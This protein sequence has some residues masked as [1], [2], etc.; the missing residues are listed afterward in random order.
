[1]NKTCELIKNHCSIRSFNEVEVTKSQIDEIIACSM[2][3]ATAGNMMLY[4]IIK[5]DQQE[6]L[7][8]LSEKCDNQKF[9]KQASFA[10]LYLADAYK[11][12]EYF[13]MRGIKDAKPSIV[14]LML[15]T[16]DAM[17]AA[18]NAVIAAESMKIGTCYIGDIME[19][20][21]EIKTHF[22]LPNHVVPITLIVFGNYDSEVALRE[23]F[24]TKHIVFNETYPKITNDFLI[25][26]FKSK[27]AMRSDFA[28]Y[29]HSFKMEAPFYAEMIR[30]INCYI[31]EFS[32]NKMIV[33]V[34]ENH[35]GEGS[36]ETFKCNEKVNIIAQCTHYR[37]WLQC[38][39]ANVATYVPKC[40]V[41]DGKLNQAYNPTELICKLGQE[42]EVYYTVYS[43]IYGKNLSTN[44]I[45]WIP[46][47]KT[48]S[49]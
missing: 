3:G 5:I 37:N 45:G 36:F 22:N 8:Y 24:D 26:M 21:E 46:C 20:Y 4:S 2:R 47:E 30:S 40:F 14:D 28:K 41:E 42:V 9:I 16:Q 43:W 13:K 33:K 29:I 35:D 48:L 34:I 23:R 12:Y 18:Q 32:N 39:I 44:E 27:E 38:E 31:N 7:D 1:M 49:I 11:F 15:G 6:T 25:E 19:N 17:I 10:L